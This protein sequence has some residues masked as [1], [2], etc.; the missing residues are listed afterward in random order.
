MISKAFKLLIIMTI[1]IIL[2][3][4]RDIK[5][6]SV[7]WRHQSDPA[8]PTDKRTFMLNDFH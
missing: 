4:N 8:F 2:S 7:G 1:L 3:C 6:G 5:F